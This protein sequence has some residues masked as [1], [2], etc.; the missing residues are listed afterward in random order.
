MLAQIIMTAAQRKKWFYGEFMQPLTV[1][2][3]HS[4]MKCSRYFVR[5]RTNL[6]FSRKNFN[7]STPN[8]KFPGYP[9]SDRRS[10]RLIRVAY[11]LLPVLEKVSTNTVPSAS[12]CFHCVRRGNVFRQ[13]SRR[14]G[15]RLP[16]Y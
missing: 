16:A 8:T 11:G 5:F 15:V 2:H 4:F 7:E 6:Q 14:T 3:T 12:Y 9:S 13:A 1:K 10:S